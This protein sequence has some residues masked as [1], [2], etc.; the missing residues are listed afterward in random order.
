MN[1]TECDCQDTSIFSVLFG[2][3]R[4]SYGKKLV[5]FALNRPR[6]VEKFF[7]NPWCLKSMRIALFG[8]FDLSRKLL[9]VRKSRKFNSS[10]FLQIDSRQLVPLLK[11]PSKWLW[12][13]LSLKMGIYHKL[14]SFLACSECLDSDAKII[15]HNFSIKRSSS[16]E[17][18]IKPLIQEVK[19][20]FF[21]FAYLITGICI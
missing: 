21:I 5:F 1:K 7:L 14:K 13:N 6:Q 16:R 2:L 17:Q 10:T 3:F 4:V 12:K 19:Q 15:I 11:K 8:I 9:L 20:V 18:S